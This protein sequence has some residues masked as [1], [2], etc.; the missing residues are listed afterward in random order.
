MPQSQRSHALHIAPLGAL[1]LFFLTFHSQFLSSQTMHSEPAKR[2][3][4]SAAERLPLLFEQNLGQTDSQVRFLARSSRYQLFLTDDAAVMKIESDKRNA[5]VRTTLLSSN[6]TPRTMGLDPQAAKTNYLTGPAGSWKTGVPNFAA[7]E[8]EGVYPG[9]DLKYYSRKRQLEYDFMI[10]PNADPSR[11]SLKIEGAN[12]IAIAND[13]SLMVKTAAGDVRWR[14][15]VAYQQSGTRCLLVAADY[16]LQG[17][18]IGFKLGAYD[19]RKALIIDPA[20][21]YGTYLDGSDFDTATGFYVDAAGF[22]YVVGGTNSTDFPVTSGAYQNYRGSLDA[23]VSKLSQDGSH[24]IWSTMIAGTAST[25]QTGALNFTVDPYG[26]VYLLGQT[27]DFDSS[28]NATVSTFPTTPGAYNRVELTGYREFLVKLNSSGTGLDYSTF[29]STTPNIYPAAVAIDATGNAYVTGYYNHAGGH[30]APFPATPGAFQSTY[31][32]DDD[33]FVMKFNST[34][35]ALVYATLLGG[36]Y[37]DDAYQILVDSDGNATIDGPTYSPNYPITPNGLRQAADAGGFITTL[38]ATGT[39]LVFSTVLNN[40]ESINVQRDTGG[41]Y[42]AGGSAGT[43]LPTTANAFQ[44]TFPSVAPNTHLG[45]VTEMNA[46][47]D[48]IY[49]SYIGGNVFLPWDEST[50][51]LLYSPDSVV[52]GG[53]RFFDATYPITDRTYEQDGC[54]TLVK[55]NTAASGADSL[56]YSGCTPLNDT[57]NYTVDLFAGVGYFP[58]P[59]M[60]IDG[61]D[62]L[63]GLTRN[64]PTTPNAFQTKP[65]NPNGG[66]GSFIWLGKYALDEPGNGGVNLS[67]PQLGTSDYPYDN[68][69]VFR[70]TGRSPQCANGVAA[71]RVYTAPGVVAYTTLESTLDA[72]ISFPL[73]PNQV[74]NFNAVIVVYD[75][76]GKAF[77]LTV[78]TLVQASSSTPPNP[79]VVSP[80]NGANPGGYGPLATVVSPVHFVASATAPSCSKG[81]ASMRIYSA[82]GVPVYTGNAASLD[83]YITLANGTYNMVVQAWDN[84]GNVY[85]TPLQVTVE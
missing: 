73:Q 79:L 77:S 28:G 56:V 25:T 74:G 7:V 40:V 21:V 9:I 11:I 70:A 69:V 57:N 51:V 8:Y 33:A 82:P 35:T 68:P 5:V 31:G 58:F 30:T 52:V 26:N 37:N 83:T 3:A 12:A 36:E 59:Q 17:D 71:M 15:P 38:N 44:T 41:Y 1:V 60:Y 75:N 27:A 55:F 47:G 29:L 72:Y 34:A 4:A 76:C 54:A 46:S 50:Q 67:S 10:A 45:F 85:K 65:P 19:R 66:D 39:A 2:Q 43:N 20:M 13:G 22:A 81:I 80:T 84:C 16:R 32:G 6:Q 23:F 48:L 14:K 78:P 62:N 42:Y 49:S 64:G 61:N 24:L 53:D 63:Y 18:R